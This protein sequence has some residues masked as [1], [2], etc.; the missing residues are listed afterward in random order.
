[1]EYREEVMPASASAVVWR[2]MRAGDLGDVS[3]IGAVVHPG[4]PERDAVFA[5]RL[6]LY[7][8]GCCI[9]L[10]DGEIAGYAVAHPGLMF[11]PPALDTLLGPLPVG[12]DCLYLHDIA[13][14]TDARGHGFGRILVADLA[15]L[16]ARSALPV[17][18]LT[19]VNGSVPYW[20]KLGF[21]IAGRGRAA[22]DAKLR[23]YGADAAY[24]TRGLA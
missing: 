15:A 11:E 13:L 1:V 22:L 23:S 4:F 14:L 10:L 12:A 2:P 6:G 3:A 7:P 8:E 24:M 16:A 19:A 5:E 17:L 9:A 18:A 20:R 21:E